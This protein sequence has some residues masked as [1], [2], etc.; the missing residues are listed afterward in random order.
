MIRYVCM[1]ELGW[2]QRMG[3]KEVE[4]AMAP[5]RVCAP[6]WQQVD[7]P[8]HIFTQVHKCTTVM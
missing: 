6:R 1:C 3:G 7:K 2:E 4:D 5:L 8:N